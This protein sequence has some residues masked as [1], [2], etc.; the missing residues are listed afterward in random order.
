MDG[1]NDGGND[2]VC[3]AS[4]SLAGAEISMFFYGQTHLVL[5]NQSAVPGLAMLQASGTISV[6]SL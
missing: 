5:G 6:A 4:T 3:V 2:N 1:V